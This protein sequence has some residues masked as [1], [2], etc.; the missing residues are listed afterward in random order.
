MQM[1]PDDLL[2]EQAEETSHKWL[3][4]FL[5]HDILTS[6]ASFILTH[7][8]GLATEIDILKKGSY[9]IPVVLKYRNGSTVDKSV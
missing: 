8:R 5:G 1:T 4:Q 3:I 6:I 2:W 9:N 7:N